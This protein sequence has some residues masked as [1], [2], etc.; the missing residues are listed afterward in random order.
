MVQ[1]G[2]KYTHNHIHY[3]DPRC[4]NSLFLG[5]GPLFSYN[6]NIIDASYCTCTVC[7]ILCAMY[8]EPSSI[9]SVL[10]AMHCM[11]CTMCHVFLHSHFAVYS[12]LCTMYPSLCAVQYIPY[13]VY[14]VLSV[15]SA[16]C[17]MYFWSFIACCT[18]CAVNC[19]LCTVCHVF[20][21]ID[22]MSCSVCNV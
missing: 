9:V 15:R 16:L 17:N 12:V 19:R 5:E 13:N 21:A 22:C 2:V 14:Q 6:Q 18:Q 7:H 3:S 1:E 20:C 4:S 8:C 10:S 11:Q